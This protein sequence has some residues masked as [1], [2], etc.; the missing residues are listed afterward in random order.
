MFLS[1]IALLERTG[2]KLWGGLRRVYSRSALL[3]KSLTLLIEAIWYRRHPLWWMAA[4][5]LWP[6]TLVFRSAAWLRRML[7]HKESTSLSRPVVVVG[8]VSAGGSGKTPLII[9]LCEALS[10]RGVRVGV[11]S[12]GYRASERY[13]R[14]IDGGSSPELVGDEGFL[15]YCLCPP[16]TPVWVG[17]PRVAGLKLMLAASPELQLV[18][19]DDGLQDTSFRHDLELVLY[20]QAGLGNRLLMPAG[21]LRTPWPVHS[22]PDGT[23]PRLLVRSDADA[24]PEETTGE[25]SELYVNPELQGVYPAAEFFRPGVRRV[26]PFETLAG[27]R[28][29][30]F[31]A[32]ARSWRVVESLG[33]VGLQVSASAYPDHFPLSY[34]NLQAELDSLGPKPEPEVILLTEK[35]AVKVLSHQAGEA[36][37]EIALRIWVIAYRVSPPTSMV[38]RLIALSRLTPQRL[39]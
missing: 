19:V 32:I 16:G 5:A 36:Q 18:L 8:N 21:P 12:H 11:L 6:W 4:A 33:K 7:M 35:D 10:A 2:I 37:V 23:P 9:G 3:M 39:G 26:L 17:R 15:L 1:P 28:C 29:H 34:A 20:S 27:K 24:Q 30:L 31:C 13:P 22:L 38:E 14:Q 25:S